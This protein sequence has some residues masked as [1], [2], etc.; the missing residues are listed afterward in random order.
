MMFALVLSATAFEVEVEFGGEPGQLFVVDEPMPQETFVVPGLSGLFGMVER[1]QQEQSLQMQQMRRSTPTHPCENDQLRFRCV[2]DSATVACLKAHME[3]LSPSCTSF[4]LSAGPEPSP[5]PMAV[6]TFVHSYTDPNGVMHTEAGRMNARED[7]KAAGELERMME[8]FMPEIFAGFFDKTKRQETRQVVS[9]V[10]PER[11]PTNAH[12]CEKE[13]N[14]CK[15]ELGHV[16]ARDPIQQCLVSHYA[17]LSSDCKCF[18]HQLLP[19]PVPSMRT[20]AT[21]QGRLDPLFEHDE[22]AD[23]PS[24]KFTCALFMT[25]FVISVWFMLYRVCHCCC[26]PKP[27]FTAVVPPTQPVKMSVEPLVAPALKQ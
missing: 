27:K 13:V 21:V 11:K 10:A 12:P 14:Q 26:A 16:T 18:L 4:L 23:K 7:R 20:V 2:G 17:Q 22:P 19:T 1:L 15:A 9:L 24:H 25:M 3:G 8:D 5:S 6:G